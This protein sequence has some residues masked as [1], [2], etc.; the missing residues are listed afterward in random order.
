MS[1]HTLNTGKKYIYEIF[2]GNNFYSIPEYQRP[3]VWQEDQV[4]TLLEDITQTMERDKEKE[5]FIGCMIWNTKTVDNEEISYVCQD[6]LDGQQ[7]F[8][9]LYLLQGVVRDI[10]ADEGLKEDVLGRMRQ[11]ANKY[12]GL[13]ERNRVVFEIRPDRDFLEQFVLTDGGTLHSEALQAISMSRESETSIRN[14]SSAIIAMSNWFKVKARNVLDFQEYLDEFYQYLSTK[15]LALYLA[16]PDN[17]DDAYNLFTVLNSRGLQLQVSDILRAQNLRE[18]KNPRERKEYALKWSDYENSLDL[19]YQSFDDFLWAMVFIKMKYRSDDNKSLHKAFEFMY[20]RGMLVRG[21]QTFDFI[22]QYVEHY[23]SI[24]NDSIHDSKTGNLFINLNHILSTT[25]GGSYVAPLMH[26]RQLF[27]EH[28]IVDFMVRIDNLFSASWLIGKRSLQTRIFIM[29]RKMDEISSQY[30]VPDVA[31][32]KFLE[33]EVLNY[34]YDDPKATTVL[35]LKE[36]FLLFDEEL[37]GSYSG[38]K[39]NKTRYVLLKLDLISSSMS[40]RLY[41]DRGMSSVEHIMPRKPKIDDW[42]LNP[43]AH[44]LWV[45]RLGNIV[46]LD[47]KKNSSISNGGYAKKTAKYKESFEN[48]ANTNFIFSNYESWNFDTIQ[49]NHRRVLDLLK[50]YYMGNSLKT[51]LASRVV[52]S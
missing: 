49:N 22:G 34:D 35:D 21:S 2:S 26:Y 10:S 28:R 32:D 41:F 39:I 4:C 5:Y 38:S 20:G 44:Q 51:A 24:F 8:I 3:Y 18:I 1:S 11:K 48:R 40:N 15:V 43:E 19:P 9:T 45:H 42:P 12:K 31:A 6:I 36:L 14:M 17:L 27:G 29:M 25:F 30:T 33:N 23:R 13:P 47:R 46:L 16:T 52:Y 7:R 37:W 50:G